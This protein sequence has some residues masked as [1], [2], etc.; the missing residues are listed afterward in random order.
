M[1]FLPLLL[2]LSATAD[3]READA[4]ELA[5]YFTHAGEVLLEGTVEIPL[6]AC[7]GFARYG[8]C[9]EVF[10]RS[11]E[12]PEA[13]PQRFLFRVVAGSSAILVDSSF[14]AP[15]GVKFKEEAIF[16]TRRFLPGLLK[17]QTVESDV[18][19]LDRLDL[20]GVVLEDI[21]VFTYEPD[22]EERRELE[23][24]VDTSGVSGWIGLNHF[25][26]LSWA[27]L[28]QQGK[29]VLTQE[30][31]VLSRVDAAPMQSTYVPAHT[32]PSSS[33]MRAVVAGK[34]TDSAPIVVQGQLDG[35]DAA[36]ALSSG[37][38]GIVD[39]SQVE[40]READLTVGPTE[41]HTLAVTLPGLSLDV[42]FGE[43][44]GRYVGVDV[45]AVLGSETIG[46]S[47]WAF[48]ATTEQVAIAPVETDGRK[49]WVAK[50]KKDLEE[51]L[52]PVADPDTGEVPEPPE[53]EDRAAILAD[54]GELADAV[55]DVEGELEAL[56]EATE[57]D[58]ESCQVHQDL[59][60][61]LLDYGQPV[62]ALAS[63]QTAAHL[64]DAWDQLDPWE[65]DAWRLWI[66]ALEEGSL[67]KRLKRSLEHSYKLQWRQNVE[68]GMMIYWVGGQIAERE[69]AGLESL[70][71]IQSGS[72]G[73][74]W[75][76]LA[77]AHTATGDLDAVNALYDT[78]LD[79]DPKLAR[80]TG[81]AR[82]AAGDLA[83]ANEAY[84]Q[85]LKMGDSLA[86]A[87]VGLAQLRSGNQAE[88]LENLDAISLR[89]HDLA[90]QRRYYLAYAEV[91]GAGAAA[92]EMARRA[93]LV[94][95]SLTLKLM[96]AEAGLH[97][98]RDASGWIKAS[99]DAHERY[100]AVEW[101]DLET[102]AQFSA[103]LLLTGDLERAEEF[104]ETVL[105]HDPAQ[106]TALTTLGMISAL[107]GDTDSA[108]ALMERARVAGV[109]SPAYA[110]MR[111]N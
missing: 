98:G 40:D 62:E 36:I 97:A 2:T 46:W 12:D 96:A 88:G 59:G 17:R 87:G 78:R 83:G 20:G 104:A 95:Q 107:N 34:W 100:V 103:T 68:D 4:P 28:R 42:P 21:A 61:K 110:V 10:L 49:N 82:L 3:A 45:D 60:R 89:S 54:L 94:P 31:G 5:P 18:G 93:R 67:K 15:A 44:G 101:W 57:A 25:E 30:P 81:N 111:A 37:F 72:C 50:E 23:A 92:D 38:G 51:K 47:S 8:D 22:R 73:A 91:H 48:D 24:D 84:R 76:D 80:A 77:F 106:G 43:F 35:Q 56:R 105:S 7:P 29:L 79:Y 33:L 108:K 58:P 99:K 53:G 16:K 102:V 75:S 39:R 55:G 14:A 41:L 64:W 27:I 86:R 65:R 85:A 1:T 90:L 74:I 6:F 11:E 52:N 32:T 26:D 71:R 70:V 9:I 69:E 19:K 63:L 66:E 109:R 13:E